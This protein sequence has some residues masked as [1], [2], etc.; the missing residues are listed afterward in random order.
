MAKRVLASIL[1]IWIITGLII[2]LGGCQQ[3]DGT[4][5]SSLM[6]Q[7][8]SVQTPPNPSGSQASES[9]SSKAPSETTAACASM[10]EKEAAA[11]DIE[12][13]KKAI[14][15]VNGLERVLYLVLPDNPYGLSENTIAGEYKH[16]VM[17]GEIRTGGVTLAA[18]VADAYLQKALAAMPPEEPQ[19]LLT[20]PLDLSDCLSLRPIR[21][22][23]SA[24]P[25][26][27]RPYY[28]RVSAD[29]E[30]L[31]VVNILGKQH[32]VEIGSFNMYGLS[33]VI[34]NV[35]LN[36]RRIIEGEEMAFLFVIVN[37]AQVPATGASYTFGDRIG[38]TTEP[39]LAGLTSV[40]GP[41]SVHDY[42]C[43]LKVSGCPVFL[44][45]NR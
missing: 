2:V 9:M 13:T 28:I 23:L 21:I 24:K 6:Q 30:E 7:G 29:Q 14:A 40:R 26:I 35:S 41:L 4:T 1:T 5:Q 45:A 38:L 33:Y 10:A 27:D 18:P 8:S 17:M 37:F 22:D 32:Q 11:P 3:T 20:L 42:D 36:S 39:V 31:G 19:W 43:I 16:E 25:F 34:S 15:L 44:M 12:G